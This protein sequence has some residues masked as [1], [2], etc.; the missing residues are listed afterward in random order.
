MACAV[1]REAVRVLI[2]E[3]LIEN[4]AVVGDYFMQCLKEMNS[5]RI[6]EIR[7]RGLLIAMEIEKDMGCLLYTSRCV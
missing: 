2:E 5:P 1:A 6:K 7:G 4:A 3:Q